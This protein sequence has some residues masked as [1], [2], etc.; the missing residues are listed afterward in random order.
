MDHDAV[1]RCLLHAPT[2]LGCGGQ[3]VGEPGG[4]LLDVAGLEQVPVLA[5]V[6][7]VRQ[8]D[9][10]GGDDRQPRGHRLHRG[11]GLQLCDR[12]DREEARP[13]VERTQLLLAHIALERHA[14]IEPEGASERLEVLA[15]VTSAHEVDVHIQRR[16][17]QGD[18]LEQ[19]VDVL[20]GRQPA[21]EQD[22]VR[23]AG[24]QVGP[25]IRAI[26]AAADRDHSGDVDRG[27]EEV[28]GIAGGRGNG[29]GHAESAPRVGPRELENHLVQRT[30]QG[31]EVED[32]LGHHVVGGDDRDAALA[33]LAGETSPDNDVRLDVHDIRPHRLEHATG[34]VL[35]H[36]G[37][38]ERDPVV[39]VPA[40]R[41]EAVHR[42]GLTLDDLDRRA[43]GPV[44]RTGSHHV[45]IVAAGDE[46]GG[47]ALGESG[48][49][50]HV[51]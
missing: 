3:H 50:V 30:R 25:V 4:H 19:D 5:V 17:E 24:P 12:R 29:A 41:W 44:R 27:L 6:H 38:H 45:H 35:R 20:L 32:V 16:V 43:A 22:A 11:D 28:G 40:P 39:G 46:P 10:V 18:R 1:E 13:A 33:R 26:D 34:V 47:E 7:E 37:Q 8:R 48:R 9:G 36:P 23:I 21:D 15:L 31:R 14:A 2:L 49:A 51:R 42:H